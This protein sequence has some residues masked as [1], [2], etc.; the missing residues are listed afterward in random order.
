MDV[1]A[2]WKCLPFPSMCPKVRSLSGIR[3]SCSLA[4]KSSLM[5]RLSTRGGTTFEMNPFTKVH[6][7]AIM[8][9]VLIVATL[10]IHV[11]SVSSKPC[12]LKDL[13]A[14]KDTTVSMPDDLN[15]DLLKEIFHANIQ[16][17]SL[18]IK[19]A[20]RPQSAN[21]IPWLHLLII[22]LLLV[23]PAY[24]NWDSLLL[25]CTRTISSRP[26][27]VA[28]SSPKSRP[29]HMCPLRDWEFTAEITIQSNSSIKCWILIYAKN[30][31][32]LND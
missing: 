17:Y 19:S 13:A 4:F 31:C 11:C 24:P 8:V 21:H 25:R 3:T 2:R 9:F 12:L 6:I 22:S 16:K 10:H 15:A 27:T 20:L 29:T 32:F 14:V 23:V 1:Q 18:N 26:R 5:P 30:S 28:T 7:S